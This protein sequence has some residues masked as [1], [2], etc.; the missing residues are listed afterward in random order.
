MKHLVFI[1][2]NISDPK[3]IINSMN[4]DTEAFTYDAKSSFKDIHKNFMNSVITRNIQINSLDSIGWIF[5]GQ[6]RSI[7]KL[8]GDTYINLKNIEQVPENWDKLIDFFKFLKLYLKPEAKQIHLLGCCL[9]DTDEFKP[10]SDFIKNKCDIELT[11]SSN[12]TGNLK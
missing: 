11:A 8:C 7:L 3:D 6:W 1:S 4:S 12:L 9:Y 5:H 2:S 10:I